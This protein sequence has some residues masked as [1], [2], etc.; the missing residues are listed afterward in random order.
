MTE[1]HTQIPTD[2][3]IVGLDGSERDATCLPGRQEQ[4]PAH[5]SRFT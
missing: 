1:A 4:P 3:V 5:G 2:A